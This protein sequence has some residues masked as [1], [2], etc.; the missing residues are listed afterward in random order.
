MIENENLMPLVPAVKTATGR[1]THLSTPLR[2]C[3]RGICG[4]RLE[5][6]VLGGR[7]LTSPEAVIRFM[8]AVTAAKDGG[9]IPAI[10]TPKQAAKRADRAAGKLS[11]IVGG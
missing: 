4:I 7:R 3:Q 1:K 9:S 2:W 5:S 11:K 8:N 6:R 10:E